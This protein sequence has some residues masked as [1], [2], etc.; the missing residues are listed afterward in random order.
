MRE[1][2]RTFVL[3]LGRSACT[4]V[5]AS[6]LSYWPPACWASAAF[7]RTTY[8]LTTTQFDRAAPDAPLNAAQQLTVG[9]EALKTLGVELTLLAGTAG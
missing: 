3:A 5:S 6:L 7:R 1:L 4:T 8:R 2:G 9:V